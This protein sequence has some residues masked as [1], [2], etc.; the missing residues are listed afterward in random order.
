MPGSN[1][2]GP[3]SEAGMLIGASVPQMMC[4]TSLRMRISAKVASTWERWSR[5]YRVRSSVTSSAM[6]SSAVA[7]IA[8][9]TPSA[10]EPVACTRLAARKAPSMYSE[11]CA[12][13]IMSMMPNTSVSPAA[14][15]NSISPNCRPLSPCSRKRIGVRARFPLLHLAVFGPVVAEAVDHRADLLVDQAALVVLRD[16]AHVVV[17]HRRAVVR[18]PPVAARR[19]E[20]CRR[21]HQRLV[22]RVLVLDLALHRAHCVVD[23]ERRGVAL[24]GEQR[25]DAVVLLLERGDELAVGVVVEVVGPMRRVQDAEHWLAHRADNVL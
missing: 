14:S 24:L 19:L 7:G 25:R 16:D 9:S 17:L 5:A 21:A 10:K 6:P 12:R 13:L 22:E 3:A 20:S 2:T 8:S 11:P 1:S 18:E 15:R 23:Q 4:T